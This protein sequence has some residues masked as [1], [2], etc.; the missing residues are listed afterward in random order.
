[1]VLNPPLD[2]ARPMRQ[3]SGS[4]TDSSVQTMRELR[5]AKSI[6]A[7]VHAADRE[8]ADATNNSSAVVV[9]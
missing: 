3:V 1:M 9:A 5:S 7:A 4:P 6:H 8:R 2:E